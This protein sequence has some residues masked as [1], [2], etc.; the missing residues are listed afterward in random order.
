MKNGIL[1]GK[2]SSEEFEPFIVS[3]NNKKGIL[4]S[5]CSSMISTLKKFKRYQGLLTQWSNKN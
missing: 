1:R 2:E 5:S 4:T 3:S